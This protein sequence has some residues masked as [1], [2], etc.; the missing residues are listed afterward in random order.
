MQVVVIV[1]LVHAKKEGEGKSKFAVTCHYVQ[2]LKHF[3]TSLIAISLQESRW[4][5]EQS[6]PHA[7]VQKLSQH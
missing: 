7:L 6:K 4:N 3:L 1:S 5:L 2:F